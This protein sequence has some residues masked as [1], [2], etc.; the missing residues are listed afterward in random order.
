MRTAKGTTH[1]EITNWSER[2]TLRTCLG[3]SHPMLGG[4]V[5]KER[6]SLRPV[7]YHCQCTVNM[8]DVSP[9]CLT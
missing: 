1:N 9:V 8:V 6:V 7:V 3:K 4:H 5:T 2:E